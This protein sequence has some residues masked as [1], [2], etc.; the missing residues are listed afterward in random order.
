MRIVND[1]PDCI[2]RNRLRLTRRTAFTLIEL[3]VVI[4][5]I[6][7][8][9]AL[10]LPAVQQAREAARRVQC[11]N[12]LKQYGLALHNYHD[13]NLMFALGGVNNE[14]S[15]PEASWQARILPYV[16]QAPLYN[17]LDW[18]NSL[19]A[20]SYQTGL[21]GRIP[22][23]ILA[24]GRQVRQTKL[25][26]TTCPSDAGGGVRGDGWALGNY[27]GSVGSNPAGTN[28]YSNCSPYDVFA[29]M[30]SHYGQSNDKNQISGMFSRRGAQI[31]I[32]DVTDGTSNTILVGE[33][34]PTCII[35][36]RTGD[37]RVERGSWVLARSICNADAVTV[38]PLNDYT[39]C[40][41]MGP[42]RRI[43]FPNCAFADAWNFSHG[44]KSYHTGGVHFLLVDGSV[45]FLSENID[46]AGTFQR[47]GGRSD[48]KVIGEF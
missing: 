42:A 43:S 2:S 14:T 13:V 1:A 15:I 37:D 34:I 11:K 33:V 30:T 41:A 28:R 35:N 18:Q 17:Q 47:L 8:L 19:P 21:K 26:F 3:L 10:L 44:F 12:N 27:G 9:I 4:A 23:Q 36:T 20:T 16:D 29:E 45:R 46:H 5:I 25:P 39:P 24:D 48:G 22:F 38:V 40:E 7:I 31:R 32:A 6:A